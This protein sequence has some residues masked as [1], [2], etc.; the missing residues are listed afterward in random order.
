M[1]FLRNICASFAIE[2]RD[3]RQP[4]TRRKKSEFCQTN[5]KKKRN[6]F[7]KELKLRHHSRQFVQFFLWLFLA[8]ST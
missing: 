8:V 5:K 1:E 7:S 3:H 2:L 6:I 4:Y